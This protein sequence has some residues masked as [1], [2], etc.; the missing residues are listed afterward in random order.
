MSESC[1]ATHTQSDAINLCL[2]LSAGKKNQLHS[3]VFWSYCKDMQTYFGYFGQVWLCTPN[4]IVPKKQKTLMFICMSKT[5]FI[6]H[7]IFEILL[8]KEF[9]NLIGWQHFGP[10]FKNK[11][12]AR[13]V[14]GGEISITIS[15]FSLEYFQKKLMTNFS[16]SPNNPI[17]GAFWGLLPKF[18]KK[19][20]CLE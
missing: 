12:S 20:I 13:Y 1:L 16:K 19:W 11:T 3:P 7:F 8:I 4:R 15:V 10:L 18:G 14:I 9:C 17:L 5:N 6:V 2:C